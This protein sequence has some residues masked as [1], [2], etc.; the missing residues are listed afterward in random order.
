MEEEVYDHNG[1]RLE[2]QATYTHNYEAVVTPEIE[3]IIGDES[4]EH[5][6]GAKDVYVA[7]GKD[8]LDVLT[9]ALNHAIF[10]GARV[11][12]I[13][14]FPP[15]S[16][17]PTPVGRLWVSQLGPE[18]VRVYANEE[19]NKRRNMLHKYIRQCV[20]AKVEVDTILIESSETTKA[21]LDLIPV[22]NMTSLIMG[23]KNSS[24]SRRLMRG[25]GK[26]ALVQRNAPTYCKVTLVNL[27]KMKHLNSK[28]MS[29][30]L[31]SNEKSSGITRPKYDKDFMQCRCF[32]VKF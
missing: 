12:L 3:E 6:G 15:L 5:G 23:T 28:I 2:S 16:S 1:N 24:S 14:V 17:V 13:H 27:G 26:G 11:N 7:V 10:P 9:W 21:I 32:P 22:L 29:L 25:V 18:Q 30:S 4:G 19:H 31:G 8:G 20:D